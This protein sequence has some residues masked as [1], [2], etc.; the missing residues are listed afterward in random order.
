MPSNSSS[1]IA[2]VTGSVKDGYSGFVWDTNTH[3]AP[4]YKRFFIHSMRIGQAVIRDL[5]DGQLSLRAMSLVYTTVI[6][7]VPL[8]ALS[9]VVLKG[10]GGGNDGI[11]QSMMDFLE[12]L[13]DKREEIVP[14]LME[15]IENVNIAA[16]GSVGLAVFV[17]TA[18]TMMQKIEKSFN[19]VWQV[20][21]ARTFAQRFS[22]YLSVLM[23]VPLLIVVSASMTASIRS[24]IIDEY[25]GDF[26]LVLTAIET[27]GLVVPYLIMAAGFAFIYVFVPNTRVKLKSAFIGGLITA[28]AWKT[29]GWIFTLLVANSSAHTAIYSA[30]ATIIVFMVWLYFG[31]TV[32]LIGSSVAF[33][34]QN[35]K[36]L[37]V[38][39]DQVRL[40][41]KAHEKLALTVSYL[42]ARNYQESGE[43]WTIDSLAEHLNMPVLAIE[44]VVKHLEDSGLF[45]E[46]K[47]PAGYYP[48]HPLEQMRVKQIIDAI[49][50][51][52]NHQYLS[53]RKSREEPLVESYFDNADKVLEDNLGKQTLKDLVWEETSSQKPEIRK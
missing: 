44:R 14:R 4:F 39:R 12:P 18:I 21:R 7:L 1:K 17:Y 30:F 33:Y 50:D 36:S 8:L 28:V 20:S 51:V 23:V 10:F 6:S 49:R 47:E 45:I 40:S 11:E 3:D 34:H 24:N 29:M 42:I 52:G 19:Y 27:V 38:R 31:W 43:P 37:R 15:F 26:P 46:S 32:L 35:P 22:D 41:N 25:L 16:L 9:F 2:N 5:A 13:G 48:A 53:L